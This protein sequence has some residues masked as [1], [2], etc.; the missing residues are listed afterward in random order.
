MVDKSI[1]TTTT[2]V[3]QMYKI[4]TVIADGI[5]S[6]RIIL[7]YTQGAILEDIA[8]STV[9]S[10][11]KDAETVAKAL[12]KMPDIQNRIACLTTG[13]Q[14]LKLACKMGGSKWNAI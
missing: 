8:L 5:T 14:S 7:E 12:V 9:Y 4:Q 6:Y 3:N 1:V 11:V 13:Y 2:E 10:S